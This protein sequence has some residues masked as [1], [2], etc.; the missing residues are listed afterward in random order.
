M[1]YAGKQS[2]GRGRQNDGTQ[3]AKNVSYV[4]KRLWGYLYFY[5]RK[6]VFALLLSIV[7]NV[8]SLIGPFLTGRAVSA[9]EDGVDFDQVFFFAGLMIV[10]YSSVPY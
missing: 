2:S 5:K 3:K 4:L 9:M 7:A 1:M 8:L 10:F 6:L